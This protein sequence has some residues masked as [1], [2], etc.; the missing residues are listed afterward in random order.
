MQSDTSSGTELQPSVDASW[1][2]W[3]TVS[4]SDSSTTSNILRPA[5]SCIAVKMLPGRRGGSPNTVRYACSTGPRPTSVSPTS[6][7]RHD[8]LVQATVSSACA[9]SDAPTHAKLAYA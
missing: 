5:S 9:A 7:E 3:M 1:S 6:L 4:G 2:S 8:T